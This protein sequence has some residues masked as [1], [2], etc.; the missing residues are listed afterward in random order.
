MTDI[1]Q[2]LIKNTNKNNTV[3]PS[4]FFRQSYTGISVSSGSF[5]LTAGT[6]L[7]FRDA[8]D[9]DDFFVIVTAGGGTMPTG[10]IVT[11]GGS[12]TFSAAAEL[13]HRSL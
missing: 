13:N 3:A 7:S 4:G 1:G 11:S 6:G 2:Q 12:P 5:S 8:T 10:T 9:V